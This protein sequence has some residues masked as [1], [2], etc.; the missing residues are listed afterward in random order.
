MWA[1]AL[2]SVSA[3][4]LGYAA[5]D[6]LGT[7][8]AQAQ[9]QQGLAV[10]NFRLTSHDLQSY[11]LYR[12][13]DAPAVVI[14][15]H[16]VGDAAGRQFA[17]DFKALK[18]EFAG[19]GVEFL[20]LNSNL[21]DDRAKVAAD[22]ASFGYDAPILLDQ[23]QLVGEQLG[24]QRAAELIVIDP[25]TWRVAY[26]G[27]ISDRVTSGG[28]KARASQEWGKDAIEAVIGGKRIAVAQRAS[29]GAMINFP[30]RAKAAQHAR[31]SYASTVAP[32]IKEKCVECHQEGGIGPMQLT[33]Y[34]QIKGFAPMIRETI[35]TKRMPPWHAEP[36]IQ[37]FEEDHSL[38]AA[39]IKTLVHWIEAGA[40]RGAGED[41][42]AKLVFKAPEWPLGQP[43]EIID[44][45]AYTIPASGVVDYQRPFARYQGKEGRWLRATSFKIG[46]R[47]AV[48]HILTGYIANPPASGD[49]ASESLWGATLGT[50]AVGTND[51]IA[52]KD[53]GTYIPAGGAIGFQNHY[54]PFGKEV[55]DKTQ[56]GLYF[57]KE[58][59]KMV[60]RT[61]T[62]IDPT[63][64]IKPNT[65]RHVERAYLAFPKDAVLHGLF[66][67]A[68]YRGSGVS[69]AMRHPDGRE[70]PLISVPRYDFNWQRDYTFKTPVKV[71]AGAK[72]IATYT[73]D[74]SRRNPANPDP[75]REVPWG[76]QSWDEMHY[77]TMRYR[78]ADET[79][80]N[81]I[82]HDALMRAGA[83]MGMYDDNLDDKIQLAELKGN[84]VKA[85]RDNF[86]KFDLNKDGGIDMKE[87]AALPSRGGLQRAE[88]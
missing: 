59:P 4:A 26:R 75:A 18:A 43:D 22:A 10:D 1:A 29:T 35:R 77:T 74:N 61:M 45:P 56:I 13:K 14:L 54:T 16:A 82:N 80:D 52:P 49:R 33:R 55:T 20:M 34:D 88:H 87:M 66:L 40:P 41:P 65:E 28:A 27:P 25:K 17:P 62:I 37:S 19:R 7:I 68:H 84:T 76:E 50:Y 64:R 53:V 9:A 63:I 24:V 42:L 57:Y 6:G 2:V 15:T 79:S 69:V 67:H 11:E 78:W 86:D 38:T 81:K 58:P 48:H 5:V 47:Q 60:M 36:G 85:I 39:E 73:Y 30:E 72:V 83:Q 21:A 44:I 32:I 46:Q 51:Y 8:G 3:M 71:P 12:M 70:E 23:N 31:I